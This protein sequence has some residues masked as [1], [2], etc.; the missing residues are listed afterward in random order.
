MGQE[1]DEENRARRHAES[2]MVGRCHME[3]V[4]REQVW[5]DL[6]GTSSHF[7]CLDACG[8]CTFA[9]RAML[10]LHINVD[11]LM[12]CSL[13]TIYSVLVLTWFTMI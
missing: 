10:R 8:G 7:Q 9:S 3:K 2:G 6:T 5:S 12:K 1:D 4:S 11:H 13:I